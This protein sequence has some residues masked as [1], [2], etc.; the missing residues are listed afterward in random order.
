VYTRGDSP[1]QGR[2]DNFTLA[3][4]R[5]TQ[6]LQEGRLSLYAGVDNLLDEEWTLNYGLP[7]EGRTI[8][9]GAELR[10]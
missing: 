8:Y 5:L 7:Q 10:F 4:V 2:L 3:D 9:G 6:P 1:V